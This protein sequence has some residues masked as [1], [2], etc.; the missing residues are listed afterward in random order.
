MTSVPSGAM[1]LNVILA[2]INFST[3]FA[4]A[5]TCII[6]SPANQASSNAL[7]IGA[8]PYVDAQYITTT[9]FIIISGPTNALSFN[10]TYKFYYFIKQ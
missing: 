2:T 5:P 4:S 8:M 1:N 6:L 7:A 3:A 10:T 9:Q